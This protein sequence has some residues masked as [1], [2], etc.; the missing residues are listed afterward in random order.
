M[1]KSHPL[2]PVI[3]NVSRVDEKLL[4]VL[5]IS[6]IFLTVYSRFI[7]KQ[8]FPKGFFVIRRAVDQLQRFIAMI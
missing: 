3:K 7:S 8:Y 4:I 5:I 2:F 1:L 6:F